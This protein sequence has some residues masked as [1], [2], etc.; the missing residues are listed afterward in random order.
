MIRLHLDIQLNLS[1]T[2]EVL[3][4]VSS[5]ASLLI[6]MFSSQ[7]HLLYIPEIYSRFSIIPDE[8]LQVLI[9]L[10]CKEEAFIYVN[11]S[12]TLIYSWRTISLQLKNWQLCCF[13]S[14]LFSQMLLHQLPKSWRGQKE[15][16]EVLKSLLTKLFLSQIK[17]LLE[18]LLIS[19]EGLQTPDEDNSTNAGAGVT[20]TLIP[21]QL[22]KWALMTYIVAGISY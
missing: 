18:T 21:F 1:L 20:D 7:E 8:E 16:Y 4:M 11:I 10:P 5:T 3:K 14:A 2:K 22:S 12:R 13:L 6:Y 9:Y 19:Q 15:R 17:Y